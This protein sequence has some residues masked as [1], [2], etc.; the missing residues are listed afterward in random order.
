MREWAL[1][2]PSRDGSRLSRQAEPDSVRIVALL[3]EYQARS[4]AR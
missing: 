4:A 2:L 1:A 3:G